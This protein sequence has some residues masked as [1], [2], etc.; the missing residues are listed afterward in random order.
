M[1]LRLDPPIWLDTPK[2]R[3]LAHVMIDRGIESDL[4]W[5][6]FIHAGPHVAECW[7]FCNWDIRIVDNITLGRV[8]PKPQRRKK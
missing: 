7:T 3:A 8:K 6:C 5:V 1:M 4:E 2:G